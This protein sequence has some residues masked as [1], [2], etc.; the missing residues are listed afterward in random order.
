MHQMRYIVPFSAFIIQILIKHT[1]TQRRR[2]WRRANLNS[3]V[4]SV[5]AALSVCIFYAKNKEF[6]HQRGEPKICFLWRACRSGNSQHNYYIAILSAEYAKNDIVHDLR[7]SLG[8]YHGSNVM[9][10]KTPRPLDGSRTGP[11]AVGAQSK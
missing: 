8:R 4:E 11:V 7:R 6:A 1:H 3:K 2:V 9:V 10:G 5:F